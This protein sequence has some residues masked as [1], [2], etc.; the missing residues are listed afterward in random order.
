M[1]TADSGALALAQGMVDP[2]GCTLRVLDLSNHDSSPTPIRSSGATALGEALASNSTL[3]RLKLSWNAIGPAGAVA[4]FEGLRS[5][6]T[7]REL[8]MSGN[9]GLLN[10]K[11]AIALG[12][13]LKVNDGIALERLDLSRIGSGDA[14]S[15]TAGSEQSEQSEQASAA[16][17]IASGLA[18]NTTLLHLSI[19]GCNLFE[20]PLQATTAFFEAVASHPLLRSLDVERNPIEDPAIPGIC[21]VITESAS[22]VS[23]TLNASKF[24]ADGLR[25]G[26]PA[27]EK[28]IMLQKLVLEGVPGD[29]V[30]LALVESLVE[31]SWINEQ[32]RGA[33]F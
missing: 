29:S 4:L 11:A 30:P 28:R 17:H 27:M 23:L 22:L 14:A 32:I 25:A 16:I 1:H 18:C 13:M 5:N 10:H 7:L 9:S 31:K 12:S 33:G 15:A 6:T 24:T 19:G 26:F 8:D 20:G 3:E 21:T 2:P